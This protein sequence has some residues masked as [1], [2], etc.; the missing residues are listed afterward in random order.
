ML[1]NAFSDNTK[2]KFYSILTGVK[3][4]L[5]C[6]YTRKQTTDERSVL[7]LCLNN[8]IVMIVN[9]LVESP[10]LKLTVEENTHMII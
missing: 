10:F 4:Y 9:K 8:T 7:A 6:F 1:L 3:L 5:I 2:G